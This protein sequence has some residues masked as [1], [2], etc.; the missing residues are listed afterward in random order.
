M[1]Y[2]DIIAFATAIPEDQVCNPGEQSLHYN[3][4]T[5]IKQVSFEIIHDISENVTLVKLMGTVGNMNHAVSIVGCWI[6]DSKYKFALLL[7][8]DS[9]NHIYSPLVG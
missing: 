1:G 7:T 4:K 5:W 2:K 8:L 6:F 3:I 9:L